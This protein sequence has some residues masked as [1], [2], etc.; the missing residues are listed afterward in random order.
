MTKYYVIIAE[1]V[2]SDPRDG[3][4]SWSRAG[5]EFRNEGWSV[6]VL[7]TL[8][9]DISRKIIAEEVIKEPL[10]TIRESSALSETEMLV[11]R[12]PVSLLQC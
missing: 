6:T 7:K 1:E 8:K 2:K 3:Q 9:F 4:R 10:E 5:E 11:A 12:L